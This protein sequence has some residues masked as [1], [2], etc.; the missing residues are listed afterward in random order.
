MSDA[1]AHAADPVPAPGHAHDPGHAA[2]GAGSHGDIDH[3]VRAALIVFGCLMLLTGMTVG[4]S[5]LHLPHKLAI[6]L[7]LVIATVKG[8]LVVSWFMHL[9]SERKLIYAVLSLTTFFFFVLL[10][11]PYWTASDRPHLTGAGQ[12]QEATA[13]AAPTGGNPPPGD[14]EKPHH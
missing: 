4:A 7:A 6:T 13:P 2:H 10:L 1:H 9:I 3:H 12:Q 14:A 8:G 11:M 5:Y